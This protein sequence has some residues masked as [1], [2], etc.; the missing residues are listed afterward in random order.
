MSAMCSADLLGRGKAARG[1]S[2]MWAAPLLRR[3]QQAGARCAGVM[4]EVEHIRCMADDDAEVCHLSDVAS[5][6]QRSSKDGPRVP[7]C[8]PPLLVLADRK[9]T[10]KAGG[11]CQESR[12]SSRQGARKSFAAWAVNGDGKQSPLDKFPQ[13][14]A[15]GKESIAGC[16]VVRSSSTP[17]FPTLTPEDCA[18]NCSPPSFAE[19]CRLCSKKQ[20]VTSCSQTKPG[21]I[22]DWVCT[23]QGLCRACFFGGERPPLEFK[24]PHANKSKT[25]L[26]AMLAG[27]KP[28][29]R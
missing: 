27:S 16:Y 28:R 13:V 2:P 20:S 12:S 9:P 19:V 14:A 26:Y 18:G 11:W 8:M 6:R 23:S 29:L 21:T 24:P 22:V 25:S 5:S 17:S 3:R 7:P 10:P 1:K 15:H 4:E